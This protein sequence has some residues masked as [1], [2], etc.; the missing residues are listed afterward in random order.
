MD[1]QE[2]VDEIIREIGDIDEITLEDF[3]GEKEIVYGMSQETVFVLGI[4][5]G[6]EIALKLAED[7]GVNKKL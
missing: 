6:L 7:F 3:L 1:Y 5:K 2:K 4:E